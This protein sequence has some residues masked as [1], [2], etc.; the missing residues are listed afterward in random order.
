[1]KAAL[2][3]GRRGSAV[4]I[5][6]GSEGKTRDDLGNPLGSRTETSRTRLS[7]GDQFPRTLREA[8][9]VHDI[10]ID[11]ERR[12]RSKSSMEN[13]PS[14]EKLIVPDVEQTDWASLL[15]KYVQNAATSESSR[16]RLIMRHLDLDLNGASFESNP[17]QGKPEESHNPS[18]HR[19]C[20]V[21]RNPAVAI[22]FRSAVS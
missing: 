14:E 8:G 22:I 18:R 11:C 13:S 3:Q 1:M 16:P 15:A 5:Y 2:I 21:L 19:D 12:H 4:N 20:C 9:A 6:A 10:D 7:E 17:Q